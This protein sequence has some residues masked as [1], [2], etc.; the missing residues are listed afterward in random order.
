MTYSTLGN[1]DLAVGP[2]CFG[3]MTFGDGA[4]E[5]V[6]REMYAR[7]RNFGINLFD[8]ANVYAG[9]E[10]E[11]IL[12]R[13]VDDHR[14]DVLITTKAYYP[15]G[16]DKSTQGLG[17]VNMTNALEASLNRLNTD[18]V[19]LFFLHAFDECTP[20][21]ETLETVESFVQK[22]MIRHVGVSNFAA[23]QVMKALAIAKQS[24]Y[25]PICCIQPMYNLLKRQFESELLPM[26]ESESLGVLPYGPVAGGY[27]TGKYLDSESMDGRFADSKMYQDRYA[28][29]SSISTTK[30]F[31]SLASDLDVEPTSLAIAWVASNPGVTAPIVGARNIEQLDTAL[32]SLEID[33]T[34]ELHQLITDFSLPPAMATDRTEEQA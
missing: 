33:M 25:S 32:A 14:Q 23:W 22:G 16:G 10:S 12:G 21:E 11:R 5:S 2:L 17:K 24:A 34:D 31:V 30:Q 13:L 28:H 26:A 4:E 27:L 8:C 19:D 20:L 15:M 6:C 3:T 7:C 9:G 1:T 29:E 18:Y